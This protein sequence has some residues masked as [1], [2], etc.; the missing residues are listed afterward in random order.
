[1]S[2]V[3]VR[4]RHVAGL[5]DGEVV[6]PGT[7]SIAWDGRDDQGRRVASGVYFVLLEA[8]GDWNVRRITLVR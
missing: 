6:E 4:G 3:D 1:M 5:L 7:H 2:I 8:Q